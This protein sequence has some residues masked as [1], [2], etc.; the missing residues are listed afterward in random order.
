[1]QE[2]FLHYLWKYKKFRS[3]AA[4]TTDGKKILL[5]NS[6]KHNEHES[7]PDFFNAKLKIAEQLWAGNVE[8]HIKASDWYAHG[9]E[10]DP[11]YDNVIL[12]VVWENDTEIFRKDNSP[13]PTLELK[14]LVSSETL[15]NYQN[16]LLA[17]RQK[18]I[19]CEPDFAEFGDFELTSWLERMY[20]ERLEKKAETILTLLK[21]SANNW[22]EVLFKLLAKNFGLNVNG[23]ALLDM[24][25]SVPFSVVQKLAH[26]PFQL[27]ALFFGQA[28]MLEEEIE[29]TYFLQMKKEY[30]YIKQK[31]GLENLHNLPVKYFRLRPDNFPT[32]RLAQ[33]T[34]LYASQKQLFA[35]VVKSKTTQELRLFLS[36]ETSSF[37]QNHYTFQKESRKRK[38]K[39]SENFIDL[40]LINTIVPLKFCYAKFLGNEQEAEVLS[41][42]RDIKAESNN[43]V[44][45]FNKMRPKTA[46]NAL[47]S[48]ALLHLKKDYCDQNKCLHCALGLQL[49]QRS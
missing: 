18:W 1:M 35:A 47:F 37:W 13:I 38:K 29:T 19:N 10:T 25:N 2:A 16:L 36:A 41:L 45:T 40:L 3:T 30:H 32:I 11:A 42:V 46:E 15:G 24:A 34:N 28:G 6:G 48:Q 21:Q 14:N 12:H 49:L 44:S 20:V 5:I 23:E 27:E 43:I 31:Y 33:L 7:G 26:D 39:L 17:D 8:I 22:E 9:H 4:E